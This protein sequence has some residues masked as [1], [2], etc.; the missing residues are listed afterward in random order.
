VD[1]QDVEDCVCAI[2]SFCCDV[3]WDSACLFI[4][5]NNCGIEC[6]LCPSI[7]PND[8]CVCAEPISCG[9]VSTVEIVD[10]SQNDALDPDSSCEVTGAETDCALDGGG[11]YTKDASWWYLLTTGPTQTS[12]HL[13]LCSTADVAGFDTVISIWDADLTCDGFVDQQEV[14]CDDDFCTCDLGFFGP[15]DVCADVQPNHSYYILVDHYSGTGVCDGPGCFY[16]LE[17]GCD[18]GCVDH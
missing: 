9:D 5:E 14:G 10:Y 16:T 6:P 18:D 3:T 8:E 13:S 11:P 15:S 1:T 4:V 2:D 12:L 7:G 17:V